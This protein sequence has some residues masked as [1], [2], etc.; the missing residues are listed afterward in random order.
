MTFTRK[1]NDF[2]YSS[3]R[4]CNWSTVL[5]SYLENNFKTFRQK[6]RGFQTLKLLRHSIVDIKI[7]K[8]RSYDILC[9][10]RHSKQARLKYFGK[11]EGSKLHTN[12]RVN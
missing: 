1:I 6:I 10:G 3:N 9:I 8:A 11:S 4:N 5:T 7:Q 2:L 12:W